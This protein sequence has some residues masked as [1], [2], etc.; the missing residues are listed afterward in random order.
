MHQPETLIAT[1]L[2]LKHD[3]PLEL[4]LRREGLPT[5]GDLRYRLLDKGLK[6]FMRSTK[7]SGSAL[8]IALGGPPRD[9]LWA[10]F[11]YRAWNCTCLLLLLGQL[12]LGWLFFRDVIGVNGLYRLVLPIIVVSSIAFAG[13]HQTITR[14]FNLTHSQYVLSACVFILGLAMNS[15]AEPLRQMLEDRSTIPTIRNTSGFFSVGDL[16]TRIKVPHGNG[17]FLIPSSELNV[18]V[19]ESE[20]AFSPARETL[21][22]LVESLKRT[23]FKDTGQTFDPGSTVAVVKANLE[24]TA[25]GTWQYNFTLCRSNRVRYWAVHDAGILAARDGR[26]TPFKTLVDSLEQSE[27]LIFEASTAFGVYVLLRSADDV[28]IVSQRD[29][30]A[31]VKRSVWTSSINQGMDFDRDCTMRSHHRNPIFNAMYA[32]LISELGVPQSEI[33]E[34]SILAIGYDRFHH[35]GAVGLAT[36]RMSSDEIK[37]RIAAINR[38]EIG[39]VEALPLQPEGAVEKMLMLGEWDDGAIIDIVLALIHENNKQGIDVCRRL[40]QAGIGRLSHIGP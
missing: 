38:R 31:H 13:L 5:L 39:A 1:A 19:Q 2:G 20:H 11:L 36:C 3:D 35:Y 12:I 26:L 25:I 24:R 40:K 15:L 33:S 10:F 29:Q 7:I 23:E 22:S 14:Y 21:L 8:R 6:P 4:R 17:T 37:D 16:V 27:G 9:S 34:L 32:G 28:L 18:A 30:S